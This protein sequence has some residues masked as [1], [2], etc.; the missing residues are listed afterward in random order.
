METSSLKL[1]FWFLF[2]FFF[3]FRATPVAYGEVPRLRVQSELQL[4]DHTRATATQDP[5]HICDLHHISRQHQILNP[6]SKARDQTCIFMETSQVLHLLSHNG[7][8]P[9]WSFLKLSYIRHSSAPIQTLISF[10]VKGRPYVI[11]PPETAAYI[12]CLSLFL[13]L[14]NHKAASLSFELPRAAVPQTFCTCC[15]W[16]RNSTSPT[17]SP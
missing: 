11:R 15:F 16:A 6:L 17:C 10:R 8:S 14:S 12:V 13:L 7:N 5:S 3:L 9:E 2:F 1:C 4:P